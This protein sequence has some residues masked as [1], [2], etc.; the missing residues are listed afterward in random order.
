MWEGAEGSTM[1][2]LQAETAMTGGSTVKKGGLGKV[3]I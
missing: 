2:E 1:S 3:C